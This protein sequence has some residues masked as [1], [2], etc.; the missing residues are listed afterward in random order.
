MKYIVIDET[1]NRILNTTENEPN[2]KPEIITHKEISK[3]TT[4]I[5]IKK[6]A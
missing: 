5:W 3:D 4:K 1:E 6:N 2:L